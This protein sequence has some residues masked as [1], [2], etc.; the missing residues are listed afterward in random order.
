P[1]GSKDVLF[2]DEA[3]I[4]A[5]TDG[6]GLLH[7]DTAPHGIHGHLVSRIGSNAHHSVAPFQ[8]RGVDAVVD[9]FLGSLELLHRPCQAVCR[10]RT[11][12]LPTFRQGAL[13]H[14]RAE[15]ERGTPKQRTRA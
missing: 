11:R 12:K 15:V 1:T 14:A 2:V 10:V 7:G 4:T 5:A 9:V 13:A 3:A 8:C 6:T